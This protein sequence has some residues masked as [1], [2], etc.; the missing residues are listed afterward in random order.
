MNYSFEATNMLL[1]C[2]FK[3]ALKVTEVTTPQTY[4]VHLLFAHKTR[5]R[6]GS[7]CPE[8]I[9]FRDPIAFLWFQYPST[10]FCLWSNYCQQQIFFLLLTT[11]LQPEVAVNA[12]NSDFWKKFAIL[13]LQPYQHMNL[14]WTVNHGLRNAWYWN[15]FCHCSTMW[16]FHLLCCPCL[17]MWTSSMQDRGCMHLGEMSHAVTL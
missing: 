14:P 7:N 13:F 3:E 9:I 11:F 16:S 15:L 8:D 17:V 1:E 4:T 12:I 10:F 2:S 5:S 6:H